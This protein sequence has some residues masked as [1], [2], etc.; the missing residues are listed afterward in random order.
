MDQAT[1]IERYY[2]ERTG[3]NSLKWDLVEERF[4]SKD[5][6]PLWVADMDF[7]VDDAI[8]TEFKKRI[9]HSVYGYTFVPESYYEAY[10][11]WMT[12]R[13]NFPIEKNWLRFT[14]GIVQ[15]LYYFMHIYTEP[16]DAVAILTPVYYPFHNAVKDTG[17]K[18]VTVELINEANEFSI[19]FKAFEQAIID[20]EVK[21]FIH[22]SPHNPAGRVWTE[23]ELIRL[24]EICQKHDVLIISDEIH[25]DFTYGDVRHIPS[26]T[27]ANGQYRDMIITA[28]SASKSFNLAA[29]A[30]SNIVI[31]NPVLREL[32][33]QFAKT[34]IQTEAN[35]FGVMAT[36]AAYRDGAEWLETVKA[37]IFNNYETAKAKLTES[38][39]NVTISPLQGTYLM[40]INLN[41]VLKG[42]NIVEFMQTRCGVAVDYGEWFGE[43][44]EGYIRLN[45]ATKPEFVDQAIDAIIREAKKI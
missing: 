35:L 27:V 39:P 36:E 40:F 38:L 13:F 22:C 29:L 31:T 19:D 9:D 30:H 42:H 20:Q 17:R 44:Y 24:F 1:F 15:A 7:K 34:M 16:A 43:G 37:I 21:V 41:P 23:A 18:L 26:A 14:P 12:T 45:L 25:Q 3:T 2:T 10:N 11:H 5:L 32:Y 8:T 4:Q 28:N 6:L 33:D